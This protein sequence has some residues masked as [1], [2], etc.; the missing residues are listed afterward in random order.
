MHLDLG[1]DELDLDSGAGAMQSM[2]GTKPKHAPYGF[3]G[4]GTALSSIF[5]ETK[6]EC[7]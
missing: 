4:L 2:V 3:S 1:S 7:V 6:A 5:V